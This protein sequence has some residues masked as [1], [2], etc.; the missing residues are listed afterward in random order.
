MHQT[1]D[2]LRRFNRFYTRLT[3]LLHRQ[4]WGSTLSLAEARVLYEI[5][6][7]PGLSAADL[8]RSLDMDR[9]QLSRIVAR[10]MKQDLVLRH[11]E[12]AGRTPLPLNLSQ[13]G[14]RQLDNLEEAARRQAGALVAALDD[15]GRVTL[16]NALQEVQHLLGDTPAQA[17]ILSSDGKKPVLRDAACGDLGWIVSSH[18][19][20]YAVSHGFS[21]EFEAYVLCGL[22]EFLQKG[23]NGGRIWIAELDGQRVGSIGVVR[24]S[25]TRAQMRWLLVT[26]L[27]RGLGLGRALVDR[28]LDHCRQQGFKEVRL[29]TLQDLAPARKLY[30][31]KGFE[32]VE[33]RQGSM[34][35]KMVTEECW[36][37]SL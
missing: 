15:S 10:L 14:R 29:W 24:L 1:I 25:Q 31:A 27:A 32:C 28:V 7:D 34:G 9:G 5:S 21:A 35:G 17:P 23:P 8:A 22:A 16:R 36:S 18:A 19:R 30:A 26:P 12:P 37:C 11:G 13:E 33:C 3:G 6:Q 20:L 4:L 2:A